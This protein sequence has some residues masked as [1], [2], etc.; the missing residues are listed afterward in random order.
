MDVFGKLES[1]QLEIKPMI[2][3]IELRKSKAESFPERQQ[4]PQ[5]PGTPQN[6]WKKMQK[7]QRLEKLCT[8]KALKFVLPLII[9]KKMY[10]NTDNF[11]IYVHITQNL[12]IVH[13]KNRQTFCR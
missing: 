13:A 9:Q 6:S 3:C 8:K 4:V 10:N 11:Q 2:G 1:I 5:K 12:Y 7:R